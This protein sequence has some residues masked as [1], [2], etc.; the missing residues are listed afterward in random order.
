MKN[1]K[2][3]LLILIILPVMVMCSAC[4]LIKKDPYIVNIEKSNTV[5]STDTYT[6][7]YS[8][9]NKKY[10]TVENGKDGVDGDYLTL[11][12][13]EKYCEDNGISLDEFLK[14]YITVDSPQNQVKKATNIAMQSA[15]SIFVEH[16]VSNSTTPSV[17]SGSG[18][19]YQM[20][21]DFSYI[22]TN[23]HVVHYEQSANADKIA[24]EIIA[25]QYGEDENIY[26][27][28]V[29][30]VKDY[31]YGDGAVKC[32]YVGGSDKYDIAIIKAPTATLKA[33][34]PTVQ[35]VD[36]NVSYSVSETILAVGNARGYGLSATEGIVSVY[37][38]EIPITDDSGAYYT[39]YRVMRI[40]AAVN[41]GNSGGGVFNLN[42]ELVGIVNAKS[43]SND[44]DNM[45]YAIPCE[46]AL[47][48]ADNII[49]YHKL[50]GTKANPKQLIFGLTSTEKNH[51][52]EYDKNTNTINLY[53]DCVVYENPAANTVAAALGFKKDDIV[54]SVSIKRGTK[55]YTTI[56]DLMHQLE[57]FT[58]TVRAGDTLSV[59]VVRNGSTITLGNLET[60]IIKD[61]NLIECDATDYKKAST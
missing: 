4:S 23:Y 31:Y 56:L 46:N 12:E 5:D 38:E 49:Y 48:V 27:K 21:D 59:T 57:D 30:G 53:N 42:G 29:S 54:K 35:A 50:T 6:I 13:I 25:I 45:A 19:I 17:F 3:F 24:S 2:K 51:R 61:S 10:F 39:N 55:T 60:F 20:D 32:T 26:S 52:Q 41:G 44:I 9:G 43:Y 37:S 16:P 36:V 11:Q 47:K 1:F 18:V 40:D 15:V 34:N 33:N 8:D 28:I 58:L 7:T 14:D 22:I